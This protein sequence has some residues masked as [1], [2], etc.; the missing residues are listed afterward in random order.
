M[1]WLNVREK[2]VL[3]ILNTEIYI[4]AWSRSSVL[5]LST[6]DALPWRSRRGC[7]LSESIYLSRRNKVG[8]ELSILSSVKW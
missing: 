8:T 4:L 1:I 5:D 2:R 3:L 7:V 6:C